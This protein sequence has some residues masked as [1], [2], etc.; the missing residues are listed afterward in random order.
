[1]ETKTGVDPV[2]GEVIEAGL[3]YVVREMRATLIRLSYSPILYETHDFSCALLDTDGEIVAMSVDV[4][5][6]VFPISFGVRHLHEKFGDDMNEGDVFLVNDPWVA[7]THLN[8]V[9]MIRPI[10]VDGELELYSAVRAHYGDVGGMT[11]GSVSGN[12]TEILHEGVRIPMVRIYHEGELDQDLLSLFLA[13]VRAPFQAEGVFFAQAAVNRLAEDRLRN[14]YDRYGTGQVRATLSARMEGARRR[15]AD[16]IRELPDGEYHYEDYLENSGASGANTDPIYVRATMRIDGEQ[17]EFDFYDC[18][19]MRAGVGNA[20][21]ATTWCGAYTVLETILTD[22]PSATSGSVAQLQVKAPDASVLN[23]EGPVPVGGFADILFG[24]VQ[25]CCLALLSQVV[26]E[27]VCALSGS[28]ANQTNIGGPSN[29]KRPGE[30]WF[31][32]EFPWGGWPAVADM[33]GNISS[34]QWY[35]GDLPM[36]WPVER[37]E[38]SNPITA[39]FSGIRPDSGGPGR[40]RGGS[41]IVRAWQILADGQFSFLGSEGIIPRAGMSSGYG[42]ALNRL[43]V[44]RDGEFLDLGDVPLKVGGF[45]L[46]SGDV[47]VTLVAGGAGYGDPLE[48]EIERVE[49]DVAD[50]YVTTEGAASDYGVVIEDGKADI[51]ASEKLRADR[52][53]TRVEPAVAAA[54][55]DDYDENGLRIARIS[56]GLADRLGVDD[57]DLLEYVPNERPAVRAWARIEEGRGDDEIELGPIGR[58]T[59]GIEVG[60]RIWI[61]AP[62]GHAASVAGLPPELDASFAMLTGAGR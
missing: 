62:W 23:S 48:R 34:S 44:I 20:D 61:R 37:G 28:S 59:C 19:P 58:L 60:D 35:M 57:G 10:F 31:I 38:L 7:G 43:E 29:P 17:I 11:P 39:V 24:P 12:S 21:L 40:R 53:A 30:S 22:E 27:K 45:P 3:R 51:E 47:I 6:H 49:Q 8:D 14:L 56:P 54:D 33:D 2:T 50:G 55:Q 32:F 13:N 46:K 26:P 15:M 52:R 4:P 5:L 9:L 16:A 18:S 41:G 1:M 25:G 36:V 42:G